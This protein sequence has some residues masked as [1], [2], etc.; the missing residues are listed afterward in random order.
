DEPVARGQ[1]TR[2][3]RQ[4]GPHAHRRD[5]AVVELGVDLPGDLVGGELEPLQ[6]RLD[7]DHDPGTVR[8]DRVPGHST[9][10]C[11]PNAAGEWIRCTMRP[12]PRL[13][14]TPH[15]RHG[16]KLR[17]VRMMSMPL[18]LSR[19]LSSKIGCPCTASSY[20]PGVP[21]ESRGFAF[22]GVGG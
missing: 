4:R 6:R 15:G 21:K 12:L 18:N 2:R 5:R 14:W 20:G 11:P 17:T 16:S 1:R 8:D 7:L 9:P 10:S 19:G 22:Q 13:M 3:D